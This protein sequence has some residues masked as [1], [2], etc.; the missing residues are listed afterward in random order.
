ML[1]CWL[2]M[3]RC[4][5]TKR[6]RG[7]D[8]ASIAHTQCRPEA[9]RALHRACRATAVIRVA[10]SNTDVRVIQVLLGHSKLDTTALYTRVVAKTI[11]EVRSPLEHVALVP[12]KSPDL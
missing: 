6:S 3:A 12:A 11:S 4:V 2:D 7:P 1:A 10:H 9:P 8:A 5:L